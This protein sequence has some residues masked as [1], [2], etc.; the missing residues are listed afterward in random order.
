MSANSTVANINNSDK[1]SL[2]STLMSNPLQQ[3]RSEAIVKW[4]RQFRPIIVGSKELET[5]LSL[6]FNDFTIGFDG[7]TGKEIPRHL[8]YPT[9]EEKQIIREYYEKEAVKND[10]KKSDTTTV[11]NESTLVSAFEQAATLAATETKQSPI[12]LGITENGD[13]NYSSLSSHY[14]GDVE[15]FSGKLLELS[16]KLVNDQIKAATKY[17]HSKGHGSQRKGTPALPED[18]IQN[19]PFDQRMFITTKVKELFSIIEKTSTPIDQGIM[20]DMFIRVL[21]QTYDICHHS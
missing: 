4:I 6:L 10:M 8:L 19:I 13:V 16:Q 9:E 15:A 2:F 20:F 14:S 7:Y 21:W 12:E 1:S 18:P 11:S 3:S 17:Q 5:E